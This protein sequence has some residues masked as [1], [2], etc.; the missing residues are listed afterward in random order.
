ML[1]SEAGTDRG[2]QLCALFGVV[3]LVA[4]VGCRVHVGANHLFLV[5]RMNSGFDADTLPPVIELSVRS[6]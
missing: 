1:H 6:F 4:G 2:H 5:T 3:F